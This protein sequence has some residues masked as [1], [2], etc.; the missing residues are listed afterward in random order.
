MRHPRFM[1]TRAN[2][3]RQNPAYRTLR[4]YIIAHTDYTAMNLPNDPIL[5]ELVPEF[6][7][8]WRH[9]LENVLPAIIAQRNR[10][11]LY[12][13]GHTLKGSSRQFGFVE[14]AELGSDLMHHAQEDQWDLLQQTIAQIEVTLKELELLLQQHGLHASNKS[15]TNL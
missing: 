10:Q 8:S 5:L 3:H 12:R 15:L 14:L 7:A 13:F 9:D 11:E 4:C 6:V 1:A 2:W